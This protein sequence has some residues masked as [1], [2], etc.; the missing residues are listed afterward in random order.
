MPKHE[1]CDSCPGCRPTIINTK[2]KSVLPQ[3]SKEM[4]AIN[5][6]WDNN[7]TYNQRKAYIDVT[8]HNSKNSKDLELAGSV[9]EK[10]KAALSC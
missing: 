10:I 1:F 7:T 6:V 8:L 9:V 2:T 3:D 4:I 5:D